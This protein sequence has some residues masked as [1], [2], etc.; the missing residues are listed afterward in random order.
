MEVIAWVYQNLKGF[1]I[2]EMWVAGHSWGG[3]YAGTFGCKPEIQD[4]VKGV[5]LMSGGSAACS[6]RISVII[7]MAEGDGRQPADQSSVA[8]SH[9]CDAAKV[10]KI[11]NNDHTS[12]PNCDPGFVHANY[13]MLGKEHAT[14]MDKEVVKSIVDWIKLGRR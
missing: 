4:K 7:S 11:L 1:D 3:F 12:W 13:Y 10:E 2:R 14:F 8:T 9:G 5:V 6:S